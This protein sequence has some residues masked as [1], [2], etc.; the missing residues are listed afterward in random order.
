MTTKSNQPTGGNVTAVTRSA[1]KPS[2]NDLL[3]ENIEYAERVK[4][5]Q[6]ELDERRAENGYMSH[7][8][9]AASHS[10]TCSEIT[11]VERGTTNHNNKDDNNYRYEPETDKE[12]RASWKKSCDE[13]AALISSLSQ[14]LSE[15]TNERDELKGLVHELRCQIDDY[16]AICGS[17][18]DISELRHQYDSLLKDNYEFVNNIE[19]AEVMSGNAS[20][21]INSEQSRREI[22]RICNDWSSFMLDLKATDNTENCSIQP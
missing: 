5:L 9:T 12:N 20:R 6:R 17:L 4:Q 2:Y 16:K 10:A 8:N 3:Q 22:D 21:S 14:K 18:D 15:T 1:K 13:S 19:Y 7:D 11:L